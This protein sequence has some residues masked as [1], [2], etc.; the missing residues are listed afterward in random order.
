MRGGAH[1]APE[2]MLGWAGQ[3]I[4]HPSHVALFGRTID[5]TRSHL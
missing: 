3:S 1:K 4:L 5:D 2:L